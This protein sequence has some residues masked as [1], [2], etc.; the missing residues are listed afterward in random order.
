MENIEYK[1]EKEDRS[2]DHVPKYVIEKEYLKLFSGKKSRSMMAGTNNCETF[3]KNLEGLRI[4]YGLT[5]EEE[6]KYVKY[7]K[8]KR[9]GKNRRFFTR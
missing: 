2:A 7:A 5:K 6:K 9:H 1:V 3:L 4:K 8:N